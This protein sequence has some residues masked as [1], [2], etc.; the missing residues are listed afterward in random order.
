MYWPSLLID[1]ID[2]MMYNVQCTMYMYT[3]LSEGTHSALAII[4]EY[5]YVK[6]DTESYTW[7]HNYTRIIIISLIAMYMSCTYELTSTPV[8]QPNLRGLLLLFQNCHH[9]FWTPGGPGSSPSGGTSSTWQYKQYTLSHSQSVSSPG[10]FS[11]FQC[12]TV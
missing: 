3:L 4:C 12:F 7:S 5:V 9:F 11:A 1:S 8:I 2:S 6:S 10:P